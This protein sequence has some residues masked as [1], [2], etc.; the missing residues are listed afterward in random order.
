VIDSIYRYCIPE[1]YPEVHEKVITAKDLL[2][3]FGETM[4]YSRQNTVEIMN[5]LND[6]SRQTEDAM[7]PRFLKFGTDLEKYH[8]SYDT[9]LT[10]AE[11]VEQGLA[12]T[13]IKAKSQSGKKFFISPWNQYINGSANFFSHCN[14][15]T[16]NK[17]VYDSVKDRPFVALIFRS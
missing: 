17:V 11:R 1:N 15:S 4:K 5:A 8:S 14:M 12:K 6:I 9:S 7:L 13:L 16:L 3:R 10:S 2:Q